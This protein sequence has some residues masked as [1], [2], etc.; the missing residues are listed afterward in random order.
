MSIIYTRQATSNESPDTSG[1]GGTAVSSPTNTGH[2]LSEANAGDVLKSCRWRNF[3]SVVG[4][5]KSI[6]L[7]LFWEENA[8]LDVGNFFEVDYSLNGGSSWNLGF[9][10]NN[11][12]APGSGTFSQS[13]ST[14]QDIGLI[15][16]RDVFSANGAGT[17]QIFITISNV[18]LEVEILP[19]SPPVMLS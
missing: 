10:H 4:F 8:N 9:I 13:I 16:I 1:G 17:D 2:A 14:S 5:K 6:T 19:D 18:R 12:A 11:V 7:K 3:P 15:Q